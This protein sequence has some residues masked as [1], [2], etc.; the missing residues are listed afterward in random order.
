MVAPMS[1]RDGVKREG[2]GS[3][4]VAVVV[5]E[6]ST[7]AIEAP[8]VAFRGSDRP[9]RCDQLVADALVV[10]LGVVVDPD[11]LPPITTS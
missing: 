6:H 4:R 3:R 10:T 2:R 11:T 5:A 1:G 8:E 7:E 9:S